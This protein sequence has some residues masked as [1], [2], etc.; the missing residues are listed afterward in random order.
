MEASGQPQMA[1][2]FEETVG[3]SKYNLFSL[4]IL[5]QELENINFKGE[6]VALGVIMGSA[7]NIWSELSTTTSKATL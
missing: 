1:V 4:P 6:E 3:G 5:H 7:G 2:D